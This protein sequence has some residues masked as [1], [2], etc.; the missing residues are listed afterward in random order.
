MILL[1]AKSYARDLLF[2]CLVDWF[3][4]QS[5]TAQAARLLSAEAQAARLAALGS[6]LAQRV[7]AG[8]MPLS[9]SRSRRR[10]PI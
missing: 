10:C 8:G 6:P 1:R 5:P 4:L 3:V 7:S 9:G 2:R